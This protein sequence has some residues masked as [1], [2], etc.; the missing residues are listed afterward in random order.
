MD[1]AADVSKS[2]RIPPMMVIIVGAMAAFGPLCI[3]MYL[4]ALPDISDDLHSSASLVQASLTACLIGIGL[5]QVVIGPISD[6]LGRRRPVFFGLAL[7][8]LASLACAIAPGI[9]ALIL[10]R[11]L[12]GFGGAAGIVIARAIVRD[13]YTG[14]AAARFFS[15][16]MLVTGAGPVLAPQI[17]AG[18]LTLGSWRTVFV[19]LSI[20]GSLLVLFAAWRLP[21]TL[22]PALRSTGGLGATLRTMRH[23]A[24]RRIFLASALACGL[25]FGAIFAYISA[26]SFVL[27]NVY[28]MS[29]QVFS[30]VFA[31]NAVGLI[32][33]SQINGRLVHR[34]GP[35]RL[36]TFG[37][38]GLAAASLALCLLVIAGAGLA[39]ILPCMFLVLS[40][41]G[42]VQPNA[43]ALAMNDF[44]EAAGSASALL[45]VL[46]F[47]IGAAVAPLV[48]LG[49]SHDVRPMAYV[50][51]GL[52]VSAAVVRLA[53]LPR[54]DAPAAPA[55]ELEPAASC[56]AGA[57]GG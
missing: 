46:Q 50:M 34:V 30:L 13:Q 21:E 15:L 17:G 36:M 56:V 38:L 14:S 10:L 49:G 19:A 39:G 32:S 4:P 22:P 5:G 55:A 45:G 28:G 52:G 41:N 57:A 44:P 53:M 26:S 51:A 37:L 6:R 35:T 43:F 40:A 33:A 47:S 1:S 25:G 42:F 20:A 2:G 8:V 16:L 27:E 23:V 7:F 11:F 29:P 12:Q 18:L 9:L 54:R 48:G 31:L 24:T 3:D